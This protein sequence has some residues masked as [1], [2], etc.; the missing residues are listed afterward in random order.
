MSFVAILAALT[1]W[2][3]LLARADGWQAGVGKGWQRTQSDPPWKPHTG[4]ITAAL[5]DGSMLLIGGR[6]QILAMSTSSATH[7]RP[8][9]M[10][11]DAR[12]T[13]ACD[14]IAGT[15]DYGM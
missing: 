11:C 13:M 14:E 4:S 5:S 2:N 3:A 10:N 6:L 8:L 7:R 15:E 9:E 1:G 12:K